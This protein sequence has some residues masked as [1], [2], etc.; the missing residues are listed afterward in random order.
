MWDSRV[1]FAAAEP[2]SHSQ[3]VIALHVRNKDVTTASAGEDGAVKVRDCGR[4]LVFL[5]EEEDVTWCCVRRGED[6]T[7]RCIVF[8]ALHVRNKD[9]MTASAKV[10]F[11]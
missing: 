3:R 4:D 9:V 6:A 8:L 2:A 10:Y 7:L 11:F 5:Y 1:P